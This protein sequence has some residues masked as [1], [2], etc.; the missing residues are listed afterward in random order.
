MNKITILILTIFLS[1]C[2]SSSKMSL[3]DF[4]SGPDV[5]VY[6]TKADYLHFVPVGLSKD[7]KIITNYPHPSDLKTNGKIAIPTKLK[8]GYLLDNRGIGPNVA[9]TKYTYFD[10]AA[11]KSAPSPEELMNSIIDA[12]PLQEMYNCGSRTDYK[13]I[14]SLNELIKKKFAGVK[15]V[16]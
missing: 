2:G 15:K 1:S 13:T 9:F 8:K 5:I 6:K 16:K 4:K 12:D 14:E 7:R 11:L 10:Y 3:P